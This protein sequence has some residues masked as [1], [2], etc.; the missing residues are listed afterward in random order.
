[1]S[2]QH[3][4]PGS[5]LDAA[6]ER[7]R[8]NEAL[9]SVFFGVLADAAAGRYDGAD[10]VF[11]A[12]VAAD[13]SVDGVGMWT[14]PW[15]MAIAH[16]TSPSAALALLDAAEARVGARPERVLLS[17]AD[18]PD[19]NRALA[20]AGLP[21][22]ALQ[23][24]QGVYEL[25]EVRAPEGVAGS[26]REATAADLERVA[27]WTEGFHREALKDEHPNSAAQT[28][29]L[30]ERLVEGGALKLWEVAGEPVC[31]AAARGPTPRGIRISYVYTPPER[32]RRGYASACVAA[33]S[34]EQLD[35]GRAF[36]CLFTDLENPT[37]NHIYQEIGY[38]R[39]G[40]VSV[41]KVTSA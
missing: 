34:Q 28:R 21:G 2:V 36:C 32:R 39:V 6:A 15:P 29:A 13:G 41:Y 7:L 38:R 4:P 27:V 22:Y 23:S 25:T 35:A 8:A 1:M 40:E 11:A 10:N 24:G 3:M 30:A 14:P 12:H 37:S 5:L 31:M 20:A 19:I 26:L 17:A 18:A 9:T 33:L 16:A